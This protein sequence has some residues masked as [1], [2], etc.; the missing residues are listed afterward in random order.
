M[1]KKKVLFNAFVDASYDAHIGYLL[2]SE[3]VWGKG[4]PRPAGAIH[5]SQKW[6][7]CP[8]DACKMRFELASFMS[9]KM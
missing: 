4:T 9:K 8:V 7:D 6:E 5:H 2:Y 3:E 1:N